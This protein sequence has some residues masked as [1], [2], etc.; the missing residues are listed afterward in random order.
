MNRTIAVS[1]IAITA[2]FSITKCSFA[3][4]PGGE[5]NSADGQEST[6][7]HWRD[8]LQESIQIQ[9]STR[10]PL[11]GD[12]QWH[13]KIVL[14][15][16]LDG[17]EVSASNEDIRRNIN[18]Q[19]ATEIQRLKKSNPNL[20][21]VSISKLRMAATADHKRLVRDLAAITRL[22]KENHSWTDAHITQLLARIQTQLRSPCRENSTFGKVRA[23][24]QKS[25][26]Q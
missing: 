4:L 13:L 5:S 2:I 7:A 20:G 25:N 3:Q 8:Y 12:T 22:S 18:R 19:V 11:L 16:S 15:S 23:S 21:K 24:V 1:L 10:G 9:I 17:M 14:K 26:L 6:K